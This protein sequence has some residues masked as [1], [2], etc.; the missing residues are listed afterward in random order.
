MG[1]NSTVTVQVTVLLRMVIHTRLPSGGTA[2]VYAQ[3][4]I[5]TVTL[6]RM[7]V[8]VRLGISQVTRVVMWRFRRRFQRDEY[9]FMG[10]NSL[11]DGSG[12]SYSDGDPYTL[13]SSGTATVY[14]Q[15]QINTVT[16][17]Y[18]ANGGFGSAWGSVR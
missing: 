12:D 18:D 1:T 17:T 8:R 5:N 15:W 7:V 6:T 11:A 2:T 13:P 14:A 10:W 16:L 4:Q 3:W 9:T